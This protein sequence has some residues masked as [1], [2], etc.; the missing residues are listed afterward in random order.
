LPSLSEFSPTSLETY[1]DCPFKYFAGEILKLEFPEEPEDEVMGLDLGSFYHRVLKTLFSSLAGRMGGKVDLTDVSDNE[2]IDLLNKC[3]EKEDLDK[4]FGWL[5][6]TVRELIENRIVEKVFPQF[7]VAEAERIREWNKRGF[8]PE[9]FEKK[10]GFDM[11]GIKISGQIDRIDIGDNRAL[12]IDYKLR[13]SN[14]K[15]FFDY[16]NLQLPI[17][18]SALRNEGIEPY[19]GYYRFVE[20]PHLESGAIWG[21]RKTIDELIN[22]AMSQ[23]EMYVSLMREGFFAPVIQKKDKGF[24]REEIEV[25]KDEFAPCSWC[26]FKDLCRVQGGT[27]RKL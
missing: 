5:S 11:G 6:Q 3:I 20:K 16:I 1:G 17:Y 21:G 14:R 26:E 7:M 4:E 25:K 18:L 9:R 12:V 13:S 15:Q 2:L 27:V 24:E 23:V 19:G 8:F 10:I 22:S